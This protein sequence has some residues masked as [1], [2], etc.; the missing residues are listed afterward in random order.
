MTTTELP[1]STQ[2][3]PDEV[4]R[5][6]KAYDL[7]RELFNFSEN[8]IKTI[9]EKSRNSVATASAIAAFA[10]LMHKPE[11]P[12]PVGLSQ[13]SLWSMAVCVGL[14]Y[15]LHVLI[16]RPQ[17]SR[18]V[19]PDELRAIEEKSTLA[20]EVV[21]YNFAALTRMYES[22]LA[23]TRRK[24]LLLTTQNILL[25]LTLASALWYLAQPTPSR[26][27]SSPLAAP[28]T[29]SAPESPVS[30]QPPAVPQP[31]PPAKHGITSTPM[32]PVPRN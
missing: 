16:V 26:P 31:A 5:L 28:A 10:F 15:V 29:I 8:I 21:Y 9:D 14:V 24:N 30:A 27:V 4:K 6:E 22:N 32:S 13:T 19:N 18:T 11:T 17:N 25:A 2:T 3:D 23:L 1:N 20:E 7:A 12:T